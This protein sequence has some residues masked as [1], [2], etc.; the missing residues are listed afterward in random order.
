MG[1]GSDKST[2]D[3]VTKSPDPPSAGTWTL[4]VSHF[5]SIPLITREPLLSQDAVMIEGTP[6]KKRH[7]GK[8][9][10]PRRGLNRPSRAVRPDVRCS[11][12]VSPPL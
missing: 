8:P 2:I 7:K 6:G 4:E 12:A 11:V 10:E 9:E 1:Y 5:R 3:L